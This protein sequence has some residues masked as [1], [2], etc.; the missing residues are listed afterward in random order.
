MLN[1][2]QDVQDYIETLTDEDKVIKA[3]T[4]AIDNRDC[5]ATV[6]KQVIEQ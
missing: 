2:R 6:V 5:D 3:L 1:L 4:F